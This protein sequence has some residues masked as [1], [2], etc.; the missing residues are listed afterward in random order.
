M[1]PIRRQKRSQEISAVLF[2]EFTE[3]SNKFLKIN[4]FTFSSFSKTSNSGAK[5]KILL[6]DIFFWFSAINVCLFV[7][8]SAVAA[9]KASLSM[10]AF[11]FSLPLLSSTS[12]VVV[13]CLTIYFNKSNISDLL[14]RLKRAFLKDKLIQQKYDIKRYHK[15]YILFARIYAFLFVVPCFCVI[16]IPLVALVRSGQKS[17]PLNIWL[18]FDCQSDVV[19]IAVYLWTIWACSNSV[20]L[21]IAVDTLM[22]VLITLVSMELDLLKI[23]FINMKNT[24]NSKVDRQTAELIKRHNNLIDCCKMLENIFSPSFLFNFLQSSFVI[25]LTAFQ[26]STSTSTI[27]RFFNGSYCTAILNQILLLCYFGQKLI[28]AT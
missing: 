3:F 12:L 14:S 27:Q 20:L 25:C 2:E 1:K 16:A 23:D 7:S 22:F 21:L 6:K 28:D 13:K 10:V 5:I 9:L 11:T 26:Y 24:W 15:S 8:F 4:T 17:F 18:P 19:Y